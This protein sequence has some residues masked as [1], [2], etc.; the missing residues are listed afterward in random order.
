LQHPLTLTPN[1][2]RIRN[3]RNWNQSRFACAH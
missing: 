1:S 3:V 2:G